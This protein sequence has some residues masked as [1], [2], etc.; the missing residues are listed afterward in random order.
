MVESPRVDRGSVA[1]CRPTAVPPTRRASRRVDGRPHRRRDPRPGRLPHPARSHRQRRDRSRRLDH[2]QARRSNVPNRRGGFPARSAVSVHRRALP[3]SAP[4]PRT[5]ASPRRPAGAGRSGRSTVSSDACRV[6]LTPRDAAVR[7]PTRPRP[8]G[9]LGR[10]GAPLTCWRCSAPRSST[11]SPS[12]RPDLS[13]MSRRWGCPSR[14]GASSRGSSRGST[15]TRRSSPSTSR[16]EHGRHLLRQ[17]LATCDVV[18][19]NYTPRVWKLRAD[20]ERSARSA[21]T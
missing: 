6:A 18:V 16:T 21:P 13:R 9:V 15:P 17:L 2:V 11:S 8:H 10:P 19:E 20:Y 1:L 5:G 7:R 4:A 14:T 12:S 3:P